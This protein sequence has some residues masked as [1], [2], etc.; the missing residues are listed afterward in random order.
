DAVT[1]YQLRRRRDLIVIGAVG[2][3]L[4]DAA[5]QV[6][7]GKHR[8]CEKLA[9][10][11]ARILA[12]REYL[13]HVAPRA[14]GQAFEQELRSPAP[15]LPVEPGPEQQRRIRLA[16]PSEDLPWRRGIGPWFDMRNRNLAAVGERRFQPGNTLPVDYRDF[17]ALLA[18]IPGG[19]RAD[20]SGAEN[21]DFQALAIKR[22]R[23]PGRSCR[24]DCGRRRRCRRVRLEASTCAP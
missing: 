1:A 9:Q 16:E 3:D 5:L 6:I 20:D 23:R 21:E 14:P 24:T 12:D 15:L 10:H 4:Q 11:L 7:I 19:R 18:Q 2:V 8:R 17:M 22:S 13:Q